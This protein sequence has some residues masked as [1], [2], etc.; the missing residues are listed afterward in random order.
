MFNSCENPDHPYFFYFQDNY[1]SLD[2]QVSFLDAYIDEYKKLV[3]EK[4]PE[5]FEKLCANLTTEQLLVESRAFALMAHLMLGI[6]GKGCV[7]VSKI[8]FGY[9][10]CDFF[11][12]SEQRVKLIEFTFLGMG[13]QKM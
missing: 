5:Q 9:A 12:V 13:S 11:Y 3:L 4:K 8:K 1:P 7:G 10:V 2:A 6:W